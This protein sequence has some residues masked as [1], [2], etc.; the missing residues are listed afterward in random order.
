LITSDRLD[1][2]LSGQD[3]A[4]DA[5]ELAGLEEFLDAGCVTCHMGPTIGGTLYRKLGL[6]SPFQTDD[7]GRLNVT[8]DEADRQVFKVP[9]LRNVARTGP[10]VHDGSVESLS[11]AIR[12]MGRHQLGIELTD[13]QIASIETFLGS[14]SGAIELEYIQP[15]TLPEN[16]PDT[17]AADPT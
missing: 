9:S 16:G 14:L 10:Y 17:P 5:D 2:F 3:S 1:A 11:H 13:A 12:L 7:P 4:L 15:P 8:K 6:V